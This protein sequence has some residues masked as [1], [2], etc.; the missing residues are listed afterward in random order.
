MQEEERMS[1]RIRPYE[2]GKD[3]ER[4]G[5]FLIETYRPGEVYAN[6]LQARWEYMHFHTFIRDLDLTKIGVAEAQG[7]ILGVVHFEGNEAEV[8]IQV[9]PAHP[10]LR[11]ELFAYAEETNF[12]GVSKSTG[13]LIR[14]V[15]INDFDKELEQ[16]VQEHGYEKWEKFA[17]EKASM[18]LDKP[19]PEVA[20]PDGFSLQSL[21][22]ENDMRKINQVLWRG[23]DHPGLPPEE[24]IEGRAF[25]QQAPNFRKDLTIVVVE[26]EGNYVSFSGMWHITQNKVAYVEPVA[27]DPDYRR[28]GLGKAAVL[29]GVR[30]AAA[31]GAQVA[32]VGSGLEFYSAIGFEVKFA[33]IPWVKYLD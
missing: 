24:E 33:A 17:Q 12:Q 2:H 22:E 18:M 29:E 15:Y 9:H 5:Q 8:F 25:A 4:V 20:L 6:W 11:F 16:Q 30:R 19:L 7:K 14:V 28:M 3:F 21:A 10:Q 32:W 13:R 23:F 1:V 26:P 27:T 31:E